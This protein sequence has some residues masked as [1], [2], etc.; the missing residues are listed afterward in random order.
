MALHYLLLFP[1]GEDGW[2]PNIPLN[3]VVSYVDLDEEHAGESE[4]K[5]KHCN[6]IMAEFYGYRLQH[7]D[8]DGIT[9]LRGDRLQHQY[10]VGAYAAIE[11][12]CL[13]YLR[14]NKKK[15]RAD[16]YQG[17]QDTITA[18]DN[19]VAAI[20]QRIILPSSFII[21]PRHI[22]QNYQD[23]MAI[24]R[25]AGCPDA[26][27]TFTYNPRWLEIKKALP[28]GRQPEDRPDLVTGMFKIKLKELINDIH[29]NHILG[30]TIVGIYV[31]TFQKRGL[32]HAHILIF[33]TKDYKPHT[34][35]D[36]DRMISAELPDSDSNKLAHETVAR[37]MM[38]GP[39][40]VAFP[41]APCMEEGK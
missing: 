31:V 22:V 14:L 29:K 25:W 7:Q 28:L 30:R 13:K 41:N 32:P 34:M 35:E 38:H 1:Y 39:C 37:C 9:L 17:L 33:F 18:G 4:L 40:G 5:K 12:S 6:V 2:H 24:C 27:V 8:T 11:Q 21:G 19:S 26:F 36:V 3:G 23:A 10:I 15:L 16:L 20:G